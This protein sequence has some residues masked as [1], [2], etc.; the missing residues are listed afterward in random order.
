[1]AAIVFT[2]PLLFLVKEAAWRIYHLVITGF[3]IV[4]LL[5]RIFDIAKSLEDKIPGR[6]RVKS[7]LEV[8]IT[9]IENDL[10]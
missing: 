3:Y 2:I 6:G 1:M 9:R 5:F 7:A 8:D 10:E 4:V